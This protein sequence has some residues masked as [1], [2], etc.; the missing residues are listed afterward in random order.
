VY[1]F[2][3]RISKQEDKREKANSPLMAVVYSAAEIS[4][5]H[6]TRNVRITFHTRTE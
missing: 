2:R 1:F 4:L 3:C 6:A 5:H